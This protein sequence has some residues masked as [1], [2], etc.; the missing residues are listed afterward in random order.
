MCKEEVRI[1]HL[2]LG[3]LRNISIPIENKQAVIDEEGL[4]ETILKCVSESNNAHVLYNAVLLLK[5]LANGGQSFVSK[6]L[7]SS[8]C[9]SE[10]ETLLKKPLQDGQERIHYEAARFLVQLL[11]TDSI[12]L[13]FLVLLTVI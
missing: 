6:I 2:A 1:Q 8:N 9:L 13:Y 5:I 12:A 4:V 3:A 7:N 10:I 11:S